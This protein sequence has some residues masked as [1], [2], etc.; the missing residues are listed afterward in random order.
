MEK[1]TKNIP[2]NYLQMFIFLKDKINKARYQSMIAVNSEMVLAYLEIG[3]SISEQVKHG[4]G[5]GVIDKLATDLQAEFTGVSGF[6]SRNLHRMKLIYEEMTKNSISPQLVAK[7]PWGHTSLI[8]TKL[9]NNEEVNFYLQKTIER[10]WSRSILEEE[11]KFNAYQKH[12]NFQSNFVK[13]IE[14]NKLIEYRMEF[15]DEYNLSFLE[16]SE[17]HSEKELEKSIVK[18]ITKTLG[19]FGKDFSFMGQQFRLEIADKEYF[20]DLLFYHRRLKCMIAIELKTIEFKPEHSQ[21]LNWYL[22][23]LDKT[24]KYDDDNPS[25]GILLCKSKNSL[26]VEYALEL[27]T[28]P[29]GV[30]TYHYNELPQSIAKYLPSDE[31]FNRIIMNF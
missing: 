20:I 26:I 13:T 30:V 6:S 5:N 8:F 23:L 2:D 11:I 15:K 28:Q 14:E 22:H 9:K 7:L 24:V 1:L 3:K 31:D 16:L 10:G 17:L 18:N 19:Q 29:I 25:I 12:L 4:W 27:T 21:Q